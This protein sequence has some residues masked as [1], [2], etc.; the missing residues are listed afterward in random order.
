MTFKGHTIF[1]SQDG[2]WAVGALMSDGK[3]AVYASTKYASEASATLA[4]KRFHHEK[5]S[6]N[7][8]VV[9]A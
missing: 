6:I 1:T 2:Q 9:R 4:V 3:V 5:P 7:Y 8:V